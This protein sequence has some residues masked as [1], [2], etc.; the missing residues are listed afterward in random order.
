MKVKDL[1]QKSKN[2]L[3][4][5]ASE[6]RLALRTFRFNISGSKTKNVREGRNIRRSLARALTILREKNAK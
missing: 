5:L 4:V 6:K 1:R 3:M 2:E